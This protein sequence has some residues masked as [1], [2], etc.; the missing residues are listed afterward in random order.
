MTTAIASFEGNSAQSLHDYISTEVNG[1][2]QYVTA[3]FE[4]PEHPGMNVHFAVGAAGV[5][6]FAANVA[7]GT[8]HS[9]DVHGAFVDVCLPKTWRQMY[10]I[11]IPS[12]T[13]GEV[14]DGDGR[15]ALQV[16]FDV[17]DVYAQH[18]NFAHEAAERYRDI[19]LKRR[20][21][22]SFLLLHPV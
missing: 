19:L 1:L 17:Y 9:E 5:D 13:S 2:P 15:S 3:D 4:H 20:S 21:V 6:G 22:V 10:G 7:I 16:P 11:Y 18:T 8:V 14:Y 12:D